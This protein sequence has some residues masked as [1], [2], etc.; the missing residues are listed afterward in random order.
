MASYRTVLLTGLPRAGTTLC[1]H[2]LNSC[3]GVLALHEPLSPDDFSS[4]QPRET[5]LGIIGGFVAR[6]RA[7]VQTS[8]L[9]LS[10]HK[11]GAVPENPVS[12]EAGNSGLRNLDVTHGMMEVRDRHL[13]P[14]FDLVVKHNA[15]FTA[16]LPD[17]LSAFPVYGIVRNPLAVL[18]SWN[19]V[20]L[21][22]KQGRIP[23][24]EK[25]A[26]ALKSQLDRT[27]DRVARQLLIL[28]WFCQQ[29]AETL[30]PESILY[31][32]DFVANADVVPAT[33]G[34]RPSCGSPA[35][36]RE[37]RNATYD[38]EL[39]RMLHQRLEGFGDAVWRFYSR[40]DVAALYESSQR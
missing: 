20:N 10:R 2:I 33:L 40:E 4:E 24:G 36:R 12:L 39:V 30:T 32:E 19:A 27:S 3:K 29:Y 28:E 1:C 26:T 25:F 22:V 8:G 17:L 6:T 11:N 14:G 5:A 38:L 37:S 16:L 18:A 7:S 35:G 9:A 31:Y 15:L 21:P 23:A 13:T 34:I